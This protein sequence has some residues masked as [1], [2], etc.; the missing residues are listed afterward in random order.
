MHFR[1]R[2]ERSQ[3]QKPVPG[4]DR[5]FALDADITVPGRGVTVIFGASGSGKTTLLRC[6]AGLEQ[7]KFGYV[8]VLEHIWQDDNVSLPAH[9]RAIGYVFQE[10]S[11]F[12]FMSAKANL[13][14][15][16]K[17]ADAPF[18]PEQ[19]EHLIDV[20]G[21]RGVL[22][23]LPARLSGGERQRVAI[24]RA[25][26]LQPKLLLMDEPLASLDTARKQDILPY[27]ERIKS[28]LNIPIL[29]V[30]H[31]LDEVARL[32]DHVVFLDNGSVIAQGDVT[33]VFSRIKLPMNLGEGA[34]VILQGIVIEHA[35]EWEL[36]CV[37]IGSI[38]LWLKDSGDPL[39]TKVRVRVLARDVSIA[40]GCETKSS[41]LNRIPAEVTDIAVDHDSSMVLIQLR[42]TTRDDQSFDSTYVVSRVTRR[43]AHHLDL[44]KGDCVWAQVKSVALVH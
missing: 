32:A 44:K 18:N 24:C 7:P 40:M 1:F 37:A 39:Q 43:S 33:D 26:L 19:Y 29:Y 12:P 41:I 30:S 27:L 5:G 10:S 17:R 9:K 38:K 6:V 21:I 42:L 4:D 13:N 22:D 3:N 15:A 8:R 28:E 16:I 31:A 11:L 23:R 35:P 25:L 20:M 14:Y 36:M 2:L 34:G